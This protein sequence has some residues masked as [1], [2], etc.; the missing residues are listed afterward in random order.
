MIYVFGGIGFV[1]FVFSSVAGMWYAT[2]HPAVA[3]LEGVE[4]V[5]YHQI[6]M[7]AKNIKIPASQ[8]NTEPPRIDQAE[9]RT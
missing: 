4:L 8:P 9:E 1:S 3:L 7:A 6:D 2:K 5:T